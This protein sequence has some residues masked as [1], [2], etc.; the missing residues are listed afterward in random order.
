MPQYV[1]RRR[2][3]IRPGHIEAL[4]WVV[5]FV[6]LLWSARDPF[7]G[8]CLTACLLAPWVA[9]VIAFLTG[10]SV[11]VI[12]WHR[13]SSNGVAA[14]ACIPL[15]AVLRQVILNS[16]F[17]DWPIALIPA[18]VLGALW[19]LAAV[20]AHEGLPDRNGTLVVLFL[21]GMAYGYA[22]VSAVDGMGDW[23]RTV[24]RVTVTAKETERDKSSLD[25]VLVLSGWSLKPGGDRV[26]VRKRTYDDA[27][28]GSEVCVTIRHGLL[29]LRRYGV[30]PCAAPDAGG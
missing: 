9:L 10:G 1:G 26:Y 14:L 28:A 11:P 30:G 20:W 7:N 15:F 25:Y 16:H 6:L 12:N 21:I 24:E 13:G 8:W 3:P 4:G 5:G 27:S 17:L 29:G 18:A 23:Q 22:D 2:L 19:T